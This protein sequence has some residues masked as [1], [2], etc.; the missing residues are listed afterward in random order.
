MCF[1][2]FVVFY[3][4]N[5]IRSRSSHFFR[6]FFSS[7]KFSIAI[8]FIQLYIMFAKPV[9][10]VTDCNHNGVFYDV[11]TICDSIFPHSEIDS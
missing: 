8:N 11:V 3:F 5:P 1:Y 4:L 10:A 2:C 7:I 9:Y 6:T